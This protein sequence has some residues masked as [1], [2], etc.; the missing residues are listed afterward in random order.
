MELEV[1]RALAPAEK[2]ASGDELGVGGKMGCLRG[3]LV[4]S[5]DARNGGR[6][7]REGFMAGVF[8]VGDGYACGRRMYAVLRV[9]VDDI[10]I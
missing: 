1:Y 10:C 2:C 8:M 9:V 6:C 5:L 7:V 3:N 4:G